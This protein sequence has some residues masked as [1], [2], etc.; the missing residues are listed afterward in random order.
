MHL[1]ESVSNPQG[2]PQELEVLLD[3]IQHGASAL[4]GSE[5]ELSVEPVAVLGQAHMVLVSLYGEAVDHLV[6][7]GLHKREGL[8][9]Q[10]VGAVHEKHHISI[11]RAWPYQNKMTQTQMR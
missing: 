7:E 1:L 10:A 11:L 5:Q 8:N 4:E 3:V 6:D 9:S 2:A